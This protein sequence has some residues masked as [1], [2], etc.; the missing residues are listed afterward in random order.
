MARRGTASNQSLF[1]FPTPALIPGD[2]SIMLKAPITSLGGLKG[3]SIRSLG[4]LFDT[5][6]Q[7]VG[8]DPVDLSS[9]AVPTALRTGTISG[10]F[11]SLGV[12]TTTWKGLGNTDVDLGSISPGEY[13]MVANKGEW[14]KL[15]KADRTS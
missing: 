11:G 3:Q 1:L 6:L 10:A 9:S 5:I 8:A 2:Q 13:Y 15:S 4:G 14:G 7:G 12:M